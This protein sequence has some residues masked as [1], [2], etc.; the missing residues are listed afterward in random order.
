[1]GAQGA[2]WAFMA[3]ATMAL[4]IALVCALMPL[5]ALPVR[6]IGSA[7]DPT[8]SVVTLRPVSQRL[9][10]GQ[11]V[12]RPRDGSSEAGLLPVL[13]P[14]AAVIVVACIVIAFSEEPLVRDPVILRSARAGAL[15]ARAPPRA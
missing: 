5:R 12:A 13:V 3:A 1:M 4:L 9:Q 6:S 2:R 10:A 8:T 7:F 15:G 14:L 11:G